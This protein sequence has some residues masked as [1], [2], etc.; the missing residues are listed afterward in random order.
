[1]IKTPKKVAI[2]TPASSGVS[3]NSGKSLNFFQIKFGKI[4]GFSANWFEQNIY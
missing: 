1:M 3:K 4:Y 2:Q